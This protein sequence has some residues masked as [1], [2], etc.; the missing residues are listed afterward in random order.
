MKKVDIRVIKT[1]KIIKEAFIELIEIKGYN[2]VTVSDIC[3]LADINRNTFYLHYQDKEDLISKLVNE[4]TKDLNNALGTTTFLKHSTLDNISETEIRW[5][6]RNLLRYIEPN[7]EFFRILLLDSSI[8][9]YVNNMF[10]TIKRLISAALKVKNPLS[11]LIYEYTFSGMM[12]LIRQW[13]LYSPADD[14]SVSKILAHLA[15]S[16]LESFKVINKK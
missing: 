10:E 12:G 15:Y 9:G 7:I 6:F 11:N 13:I 2:N 3:K 16:N 1:K 4:A 14:V 5:G 8:T